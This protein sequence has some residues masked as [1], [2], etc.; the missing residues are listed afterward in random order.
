MSGHAWKTQIKETRSHSLVQGEIVS[1]TNLLHEEFFLTFLISMGIGRIGEGGYF[2]WYDAARSVWHVIQSDKSQREMAVKSITKLP[3]SVFVGIPIG[4]ILEIHSRILWAQKQAD[5]LSVA[6][7]IVAHS[8]VTFRPVFRPK[9]DG[10]PVTRNQLRFVPTFGGSST[11]REHS[12]RLD[13]IRG[14]KLWRGLRDDIM[15]VKEYVYEMNQYLLFPAI[16]QKD[17]T[18]SAFHAPS[19]PRKPRLSSLT[20]F[21]AI[22]AQLAREAQ[23]Q[24]LSNRRRPSPKKSRKRASHS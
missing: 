7:N 22:E 4:D 15:K 16:S 18:R 8:P 17:K 14:L 20:R 1:A 5:N 6:R 2:P 23:Q 12:K 9:E 10:E 13:L 19:L 21:Q 11:R 24:E 3:T